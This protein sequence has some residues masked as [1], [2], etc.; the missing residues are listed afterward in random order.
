MNYRTL[1]ARRTPWLVLAAAIL[2]AG[3]VL[4]AFLIDVSAETYTVTYDDVTGTYQAD[5]NGTPTTVYPVNVTAGDWTVTSVL[6][7]GDTYTDGSAFYAPDGIAGITVGINKAGEYW[8]PQGTDAQTPTAADFTGGTTLTYEFSGV[9]LTDSSFVLEVVPPA[10]KANSAPNDVWQGNTVASTAYGYYYTANKITFAPMVQLRIEN[11]MV[12][13]FAD[14]QLYG[15]GNLDGSV[16]GGW[17]IPGNLV[18]TLDQGYQFDTSATPT[19]TDYQTDSAAVSFQDEQTLELTSTDWTNVTSVQITGLSVMPQTE[20][21]VELRMESVPG[22]SISAEGL[23]NLRFEAVDGEYAYGYFLPG[24]T[25]TLKTVGDYRFGNNA[26]WGQTY[27]GLTLTKVNSQ[28]ITI[29]VEDTITDES[30]REVNDQVVLDMDILAPVTVNFAFSEPGYASALVNY[31]EVTSTTWPQGEDLAFSLTADSAKYS[32]NDWSAAVSGYTVEQTDTGGTGPETGTVNAYGDGTIS[33]SILTGDC[34]VTFTVVPDAFT[35]LVTVTDASGPGYALTCLSGTASG[36]PGYIS[37]Y[38]KIDADYNQSVPVLTAPTGWVMQENMEG[39]LLEDDSM[40]YYIIMTYGD[41]QNDLV[42]ADPMDLTVTVSGIVANPTPDPPSGGG[43]G[44]PAEPEI[45]VENELNQEG[46]SSDTMLWPNGTTERNGVSTTTVTDEELEALIDLAQQ[47]ME[48][49]QELE[50]DGYKEGIIVIEDLRPSSD[51]QTYILELTD[52]QFQRIAQEEWDRFTVQTPAGWVSLYGDTINQVA[53]TG[54]EVTVTI[55]RLEHEGRPGADV[56]LTAGGQG[57]TEFPEVYGVRVFVPYEPATEEDV[58]ALL[59][60]YIHE[61]GTVE[62]VTESF[63]DQTAGGVYVFTGHLSKF[64]VAYRPAVFSDVGADH[65]ANPYVTFLAARGLLGT[66]STFR[67]DDKATRGEM[68]EL[69][70]EAL[71]AANLPSRAVQVYSDVSVT[72]SVAKAAAWAYFNNLTGSITSGSTLRPNEAITRE[73]MAALTGNI[74]SGVGLRL[75]S[76][77]LDTGYTD[78]N[79][80]ASYARTAVTR[81]RAAGILEMPDN[82]KFSPDA[83]LNRGEMAQI[84]ATLLS[85]L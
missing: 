27:S 24:T 70:A 37:L 41:G 76:K 19:V 69:L 62:R 59:M 34:T 6:A 18:L 83:T 81:L 28:T 31:E 23:F 32:V 33:G 38:L 12:E 75:R 42:P 77:G 80:V 29:D 55:T 47:H 10:L 65:W 84:V 71:S 49:I 45:R 64:G 78:L 53:G 25:I 4:R 56:T 11:P 22:D 50:G 5:V 68:L 16:Y 1:F 43:G 73:N 7:D 79:E 52:S 72:S 3:L 61:D 9:S 30:G 67:P 35:R 66:G 26:G 21:M 39:G 15:Q 63:Y 20:G 36:E 51:I 46:A 82:Y 60:E 85:S 13:N 8:L 74:A 57:M 17:F 40:E 58:N 2:V 54:G 48:D 14:G 44:S